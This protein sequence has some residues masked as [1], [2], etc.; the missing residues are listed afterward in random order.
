MLKCT[1]AFVDLQVLILFSVFPF[2]SF[3]WSFCRFRRFCQN[4]KMMR[5]PKVLRMP[6]FFVRTRSCMFF[7]FSLPNYNLSPGILG[8]GCRGRG[9]EMCW[10]VPS[11]SWICRSLCFFVFSNIQHIIYNI[12]NIHSVFYI[13][14]CILHIRY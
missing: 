4:W 5:F 14:Y 8:G 12:Q 11:V 2:F 13:I 3:V 10:N 1:I 6:G 9:L 7:R